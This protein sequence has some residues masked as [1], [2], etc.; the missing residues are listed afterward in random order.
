MFNIFVSDNVWS[1]IDDLENYLI[2]ELK[3]SKT[4]A[5]QRTGR[6]RIFLKSITQYCVTRFAGLSNGAN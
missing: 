6:M 1:K 2:D 5:L 3:L 4:A